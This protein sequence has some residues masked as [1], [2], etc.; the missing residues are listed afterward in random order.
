[1]KRARI[2]IVLEDNEKGGVTIVANPSFEQMAQMINS[3]E[4]GTS[5]HGY[6]MRMM[7]E[8]RRMSK[9]AGPS[10]ILIPRVGR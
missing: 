9:E 7:N 6:A 10:K 4:R 3:G 1:M 2:L 5:A 8:A